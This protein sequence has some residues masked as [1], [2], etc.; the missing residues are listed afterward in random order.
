MVAE[1]EA[2]FASLRRKM[3][4]DWVPQLQ[5]LF[6]IVSSSLPAIWDADSMY[7]PKDVGGEDS[8]VLGEINVSAVFPFPESA[9][10]KIAPAVTARLAEAR[11]QRRA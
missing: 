3:E 4:L 7:G 5:R 11:K 1:D 2:R 6:G 8:Y 10:Q 9:A